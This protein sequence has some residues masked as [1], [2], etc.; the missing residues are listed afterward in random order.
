[1]CVHASRPCQTSTACSRRCSATLALTLT[2]A[3]QRNRLHRQSQQTR[4][5]RLPECQSLQQ[6]QNEVNYLC[7]LVPAAGMCSRSA[8]PRPQQ[9]LL[10]AAAG[11]SQQPVLDGQMGKA[12]VLQA[13]L[14]GADQRLWVAKLRQ[15]QLLMGLGMAMTR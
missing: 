14:R 15:M 11:V 5:R 10:R 7:M 3:P 8:P 4:G 6:A 2:L 13:S 1:M 9:E 12:M